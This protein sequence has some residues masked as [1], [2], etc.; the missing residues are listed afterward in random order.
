MRTNRLA[1]ITE[2]LRTGA[3]HAGSRPVRRQA[4]LGLAQKSG[5][6]AL[7]LLLGLSAA[8]SATELWGG[9]LSPEDGPRAAAG[10]F[11]RCEIVNLGDSPIDVTTEIFDRE[12]RSLSGPIT[13]PPLGPR[14]ATDVAVLADFSANR[15]PPI[16]KF[17]GSFSKHRVRATASVFV[18][19]ENGTI[20]AVEAH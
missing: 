18:P 12:G 10:A 7:A 17:S 6:L 11:L 14:A 16:C 1:R 13:V 19:E 8:A 3:T 2:G 5:A 4:W 9:P 15:L 20:A